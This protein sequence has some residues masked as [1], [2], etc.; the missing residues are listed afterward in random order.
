MTKKPKNE[1]AHVRTD[2]GMNTARS[3][4]LCVSLHQCNAIAPKGVFNKKKS[5]PVIDVLIQFILILRC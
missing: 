5:I 2:F 3:K 1:K 4:R